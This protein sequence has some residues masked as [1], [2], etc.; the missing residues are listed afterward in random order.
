LAELQ[1]LGVKPS[2]S[3]PHVSD[4]NAF[5]EA[6]FRTEKYRLEFPVKGFATL[7]TLRRC[8]ARFVHG[9]TST[10]CAVGLRYLPAQRHAWEG[11]TRLAQSVTR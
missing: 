5:V 2:Y 3:T 7:D 6:L 10:T 4:D 1:W 8:A 9:K 11:Q